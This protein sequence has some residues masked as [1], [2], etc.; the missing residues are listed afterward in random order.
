[1]K[2]MPGIKRPC[3]KPNKNDVWHFER[4]LKKVQYKINK[5]KKRQIILPGKVSLNRDA[6]SSKT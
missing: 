2:I 1:M 6:N 5:E 4:K 3:I